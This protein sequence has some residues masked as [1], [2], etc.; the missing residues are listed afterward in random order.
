MM[1]TLRK[2]IRELLTESINP[3]IMS[4]IDRLQADDLK[5]VIK[6]NDNGTSVAEIVGAEKQGTTVG[7]RGGVRNGRRIR[8]YASLTWIKTDENFDGPCL[9]SYQVGGSRAYA[10]Y[11]PLLYDIA[12]E[13]TGGLTADRTSVSD[14]A[15]AVWDYYSRN[16]PDVE[17]VQLDIPDD[18]FEDQ[19]T[20]DDPSDDCSQVPAYD[21]YGSGWHK[22]GLSK[23]IKKSGTPVID[24]LRNRGI[25]EEL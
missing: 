8:V 20:P 12:I 7:W 5:I 19:L 22:S 4:M 10:G 25:L 3:K 23:L 14:S 24:E 21:R 9:Q 17:V 2:Y 15:E 6:R 18:Y 13:F 16:R 1:E 11:G